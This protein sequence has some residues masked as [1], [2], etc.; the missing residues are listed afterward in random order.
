MSFLI[1]KPYQSM[2]VK[3]YFEKQLKNNLAK[4]IESYISLIES[5]NKKDGAHIITYN[6]VAMVSLVMAAFVREEK[7]DEVWALQEYE[8]FN[9][10]GKFKG[11]GDLFVSINKNHL[12]CDLLIEAKRDGEFNK[13]FDKEDN[14]AWQKDME[15]TMNQCMK[16]YKEEKSYFIEP[17]FAVTMCFGTF[18]TKDKTRYKEQVITWKP[19]EIAD[20]TSYQFFIPL[21][22]SGRQLCVYG[23]ILK[24]N[25]EL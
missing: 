25:P 9:E 10:K 11:R 16:Y 15:K 4:E 17:T 18:N 6:E 5:R 3:S 23:Q 2:K 1:I 13:K 24:V 7:R 19:K 12:K 8:V 22:N 14:I 21:K 20:F